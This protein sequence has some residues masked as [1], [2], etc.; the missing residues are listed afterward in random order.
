MADTTIKPELDE[1][2]GLLL[3]P[4]AGEHLE[5]DVLETLERLRLIDEAH[6]EDDPTSQAYLADVVQYLQS[7][8]DIEGCSYH[9][10]KLFYDLVTQA[11][12]HLKKK[13]QTEISTIAESLFGTAGTPADGTSSS[14]TPGSTT[15]DGS[16]PKK[17]SDSETSAEPTLSK[18]KS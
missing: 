16:R 14:E 6:K 12:T 11:Y 1:E 4:F 2:R 10:A 7:Q 18:S 5:I 15:C 3:L 9:Q 13:Q 8:H 17:K